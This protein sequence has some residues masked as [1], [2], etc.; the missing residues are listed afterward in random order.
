MMDRHQ[1]TFI[2]EARELLIDLEESLLAIEHDP[3]NSDLIG[4]IFRAMHT[5]KGSSAMFGFDA[6]AKFTHEIENAFD[7]VREGELEVTSELISLTL[8][9]RDH[10]SILLDTLVD[11]KPITEKLIAQGNDLLSQPVQLHSQ[12]KHEPGGCHQ[13]GDAKQLRMPELAAFNPGD[14]SQHKSYCPNI[15]GRLMENIRI[16]SGIDPIT[17]QELLDGWNDKVRRAG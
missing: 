1:Q 6:I 14:H 3:K 15:Q 8:G 9:S 13:D 2:E 7:R 16:E 11:E 4:K 5:I 12:G 17:P 10:I